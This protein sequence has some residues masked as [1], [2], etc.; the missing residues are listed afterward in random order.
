MKYEV[1]KLGVAGTGDV[2]RE[3]NRRT[4]NYRSTRFKL[5]SIYADGNVVFGV[6][7]EIVEE[8]P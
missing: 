5:V 8:K 2:E 1:H 6:F 4:S 7:E 3:L